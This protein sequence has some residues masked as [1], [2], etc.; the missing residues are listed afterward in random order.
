M[1]RGVAEGVAGFK[2]SRRWS[3]GRRSGC[4]RGG[5][6]ELEQVVGGGDQS[7]FRAHRGSSSTLEAVAATVELGVAEDR[8]DHA[9]AFGVGSYLNGVMAGWTLPAEMVLRTFTA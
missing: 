9:L 2:Q 4:G 8:F 1:A 5:A 6:P 3:L 7:P